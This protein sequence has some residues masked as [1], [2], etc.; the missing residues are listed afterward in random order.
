MPR[1][2]PAARQLASE[3]EQVTGKTPEVLDDV[4]GLGFQR[5]IRLTPAAAKT[6]GEAVLAALEA[7][8]RVESVVKSSKGTRIT[9][10]S[11]TRADYATEFGLASVVEAD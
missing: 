9:F 7:D 8:R 11:D 2:V 5:S 4:D 1:L 6:L 10:V 3:V